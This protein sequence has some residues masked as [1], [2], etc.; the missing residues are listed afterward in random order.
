[1]T[2]TSTR[3]TWP[4]LVRSQRRTTHRLASANIGTRATN[5][6][7]VASLVVVIECGPRETASSRSARKA[8][9]IAARGCRLESAARFGSKIRGA[10]T[11]RAPRTRPAYG[12]LVRGR[13]SIE[14]DA[15]WSA[16]VAS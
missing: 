1:V 14:A 9:R 6:C 15:G 11:N 4:S 13:F 3:P 7:V 10:C 8:P 12:G 2:T 16:S 5:G